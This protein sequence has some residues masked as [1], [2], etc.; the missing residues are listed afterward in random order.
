MLLVFVSLSLSLSLS[1]C[2]RVYNTCSGAHKDRLEI[3]RIGSSAVDVQ[4][5]LEQDFAPPAYKLSD[6]LAQVWV[7]SLSLTSRSEALCAAAT[8]TVTAPVIDR[9]TACRDIGIYTQLG[10]WVWT[11]LLQQQHNP[12][13]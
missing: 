13:P 5:T 7:W 3:K 8:A 2:R 10:R 1:L 11:L 6:E 9:R 12:K 4:I